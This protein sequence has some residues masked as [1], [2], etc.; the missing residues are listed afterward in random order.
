MTPPA[1]PQPGRSWR[2]VVASAGGV[3]V[4]TA[5]TG[6]KMDN[7]RAL[8]AAQRFGLEL[9]RRLVQA[10]VSVAP[11]VEGHARVVWD[12]FLPAGLP[13]ER[14]LESAIEAVVSARL[15]SARPLHALG[16]WHV[17]E[18]FLGLRARKSTA[19]AGKTINLP[20]PVPAI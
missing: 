8:R 9:S 7:A 6:L 16:Q 4:S 18:A 5:R 3:Q 14:T 17:A 12:A 20:A 11:S 1:T 10:R 2:E 19:R 15:L 13:V